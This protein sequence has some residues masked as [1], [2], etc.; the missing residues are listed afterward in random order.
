[1]KQEKETMYN[2]EISHL[3]KHYQAKLK[4]EKVAKPAFASLSALEAEIKKKRE[5]TSDVESAL[6][7]SQ[8]SNYEHVKELRNLDSGRFLNLYS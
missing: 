3:I 8:H 5:Y 4:N 7:T 2:K 1:M 6:E